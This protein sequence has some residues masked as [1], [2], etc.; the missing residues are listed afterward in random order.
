MT[1]ITT[2][3]TTP[4]ENTTDWYRLSAEDVCRQLDVDPAVGLSAAE[5]L[6]RRQRY[7]PNKL[8]EEAKEPG[9]RA[10][11]R[12]YRDLMQLVLL[13]AAIVSI[14]AL[15]DVSTGLVVIGLT[16]VNA[17]MGLH[18]EGKAAESVAALRQMLIMTAN[19]RRDGQRVQIPAEEL[20][21][22]DIVGFEAGDKVAADGRVLVAATLEI[23]EAGLTGESTPV[24]KSVDPVI[25]E[26]APLGDRVDMAYMNSQVTRGRG[27]IVV[28]AT[29][30]SSEVGHISGMLSGVEQEKSPLTK[31]LDQL[32]VIIT[33]MAA[34]A[35]ALIIILGLARG[36]DFDSLFLTGITLA[37]A[38]IP[39][40]LPA[41]VTML[42]SVGTQQLAEKGA[43]VKRL[44]SV[45][46]LG[47][48]SAICSDK[49][50]TLTLNQMT[51]R[52]LVIVGRRFSVDGE[53]YSTTGRILRVAGTGDSSLEPFV[54]PMALANDA[55]IR[56]GACIGDP[57]EGALVVLAA[58]GGL[59]VEETR[60][61]YPRV[62]EV[63]FD[64]EYKLMATFH[65]MDDD[66]RKV[67]RCFV[68]GAP[69][70]LLARSSHYLDADG[71]PEPM[72]DATTQVLAEND[73]LA[74]DGMRVLA[75]ARRD[76]DPAS[77]D[78]SADLLA[79][80]T[81]LQLLALVGIVDPPRKEAKDAIALCKDAGIRV[82]MITGDHATTAAAIAGQLGIYG[83]A[84]TGAEFAALS[85]DQLRAEV[86]D[87]GVVARV[88][89]ED[90]VRLVSIL[91]G[92]GNIVAMTGDG[93]N[94]AP[95]LTRADIGVAMG[96]TGTEVTKDAAE[97]ILTDD[98]FATIVT[99]VEGGRGLYD[100]LMKY[101]RVQMIMLAGFILLFVGAGI[102]TIAN[103][104]PLLPL[105]IL[106]INFAIDVLL[107][108]GLGFD[109][110]TPG[111]MKRRPRS[112]D[113]PVIAP[114]L[115]VRLG[116]AGL[117]IAA[118]TLA[119]VAW[120]E[121]RYDLA[122]ATTMGLTT[123]SLLHIVAALEWRDPMESVFNRATIANRRF[124]LL[125]LAAL[126]LTFLATTIDGLNRLLDTVQ[127]DG[128]Q[129]RVCLVAVIGYFVLAEL[130]KLVLR[131][132]ERRRA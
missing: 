22:G 94:D 14:V 61:T 12:Q 67:V 119:V 26:N 73:R 65:E 23:E 91:K 11:L 54:L 121:D 9:W 18:Q 24:A 39:T 109:A 99:A 16:V 57:T 126:A 37:I 30:M 19:V 33:I 111:L 8:A 131:Q 130:A 55:V 5:V 97:M 59:D 2:A 105:Q 106:W 3:T 63:P 125:L 102:F 83:K 78:P 1:A 62:A 28:T 128:D 51:A 113:E 74:G 80:V 129:W 68:K 58:K 87:I 127:L 40:G 34:G 76:F 100:N 107:A 122:T 108:L 48:T 43:I 42:L 85:D 38:A 93:V 98:N 20:V 88:A 53:G 82:R 90:K 52:D 49:T 132:I 75:V 118:G 70:V 114:A 15:Q 77:F 36:E 25:E 32:T 104:T 10:F 79:L 27:E 84:L 41:V 60:K 101:V 117:L 112:P 7:G 6:D 64:A 81:D 120:G 56:D 4:A 124:N 123:I 17:L 96:I 47:S 103:G 71:A 92:Q 72:G 95:A 44:K 110:P 31:Q 21:P 69:D 29:G 13:G 46:T 116:I 115:G 35:L 50:G 45:E 89:P 66:G 86:E